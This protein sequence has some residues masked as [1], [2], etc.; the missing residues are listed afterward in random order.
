MRALACGNAIEIASAIQQA[1][2]C[3]CVFKYGPIMQNLVG[4]QSLPRRQVKVQNRPIFICEQIGQALEISPNTAASRY[5]YGL[6]A[7]RQQLDQE[8]T[9]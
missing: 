3:R 9:R 8:L 2:G 6:N 4:Y 5:R 1:P 7:L